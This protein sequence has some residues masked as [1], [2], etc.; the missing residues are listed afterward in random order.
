M[1]TIE[2]I[3]KY[4]DKFNAI[5]KKSIH[6]NDLVSA[7]DALY[8]SGALQHKVNIH[9]R[10][11]TAEI[12][13]NQL[14]LKFARIAYKNTNIYCMFYDSIAVSNMALSM[15]YL[16][17]LCSLGK[18]FVYVVNIYE[19]DEKGTSQLLKLADQCE[20]CE[21]IVID[22]NLNMLEKVEAIRG[23]I[24]KWKPGK[25]L[26]HMSNSDSIGC[27]AF[28]NISGCTKYL[29][30]HG[31]EQFWL[32]A[33]IL[34]FSIEFRGMGKDASV[35]YRGL[36]N[37]QCLVLP[38][39]PILREIPFQGFDFQI[40]DDA[41]RIFSGGRFVKVYAENCIFIKT[42]ADILKRHKNTFFVF[43]GS[44]DPEPMKNYVLQNG[45]K[46]RWK[47]IPYRDDLL[48]VLKRMDI[49]LGTYPQA[50][51]LM[52]QYAAVAGLP[53]VEMDTKNGGI[54]EDLLP[55]FGGGYRITYESW[56]DYNK[57][58]DSLIDDTNYRLNIAEEVK[59]SNI[60]EE[61]F[62]NGLKNL[63]ESNVSQY[64]A[65][66]REIDL[67]I[68]TKRLLEAENS[69]MHRIPGI[70]CNILM[71]KHYPVTAVANF[72]KFIYFKRLMS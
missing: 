17:A 11:E 64:P 18:K 35:E 34:D 41:I 9:L 60:T 36:A 48:E 71:L 67:E 5:A 59:S 29:I 52:A 21:T 6:K 10:D 50:G 53:I 63:L 25:A 49:Y 26:L 19:W 15:Q 68:R 8:H 13:M 58:V 38:Y 39:Y 42:V 14:S 62:C 22:T 3:E 28:G 7:L 45:L 33:S 65:V 43:A 4:K 61:E 47:V 55:K 2:C 12:L 46:K 27:V 51:G 66:H 37:D 24:S 20:N 40:P 23:V 1:Y 54:T 69:Y 31:D 16:K 44:G 56:E 70:M 32:G 30:N 72:L 57:Q